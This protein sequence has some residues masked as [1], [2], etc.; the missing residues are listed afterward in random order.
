MKATKNGYQKNHT[1]K[2]QPLAYKQHCFINSS[3]EK[4]EKKK[5]PVLLSD[6][7][8][9]LMEV[10]SDSL[11][12]EKNKTFASNALVACKSTMIK[13]RRELGPGALTLLVN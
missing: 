2:K 10:L 11:K 3:L 7:V 12:K 6:L 4:L 13:T 8:T 9:I 5:T 1:Q